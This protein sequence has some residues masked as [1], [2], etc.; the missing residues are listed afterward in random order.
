MHWHK[1][2]IWWYHFSNN[3]SHSSRLCHEEMKKVL[4]TGF[5]QVLG[6]KG[7]YLVSGG[8]IISWDQTLQS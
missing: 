4:V 2:L 3:Y 5:D 8:V 6:A 1:D 7:I